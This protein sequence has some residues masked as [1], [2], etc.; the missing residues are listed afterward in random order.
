MT[1]HTDTQPSRTELARDA[2]T[3]QL[4]EVHSLVVALGDHEETSTD[5]LK[6]VSNLYLGVKALDRAAIHLHAM[7]EEAGA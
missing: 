1:T 7:R 5:Q 4:D 6:A 3:R 2:Y